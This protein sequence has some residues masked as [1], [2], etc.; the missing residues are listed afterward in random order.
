[1]VSAALLVPVAFGVKVAVSV[2]LAP[3]A[4]LLPHV[5]MPHEKSAALVPVISA[6]VK[7]IVFV[8]ELVS[9][10]DRLALVVF[11][12]WSANVTEVGLSVRIVPVDVPFPVRLAVCGLPG[13]SS[14]TMSE[15]VRVPDALG[16]NVTLIVQ[17][18]PAARLTPQ[19]FVWAKLLLLVPPIV[20]ALRVKEALPVLVIVT[21]RAALVVF[22]SWFPK[23]SD[24][25]ES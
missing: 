11:N 23:V 3:T 7:L 15:A 2:Q 22:T 8:P 20:I 4:R 14:V 17:L 13:A 18:A 24:D 21:V 5:P 16:V 12:T 9:V 25:G 19:V 10:I 6:L 1:M